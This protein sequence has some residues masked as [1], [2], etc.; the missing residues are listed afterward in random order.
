S[1][2][3]RIAGLRRAVRFV[4]ADLPGGAEG[5]AELRALGERRRP[6][7]LLIVVQ[8]VHDGSG[9]EL[10]WTAVAGLAGGG[11]R[12]LTSR[13]TREH[14]LIAA[15]DIAPTILERLAVRPMPAGVRGAAIE[16]DGALHSSS[17]RALM[18][19][20]RVIGGR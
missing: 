12:E 9:G 11:G 4:V 17:L 6:E 19:R 15:I 8:R 3:A 5:M 10:L 14:G 16:T 13:T 2:P 7:D 18:A 20:L 1:L